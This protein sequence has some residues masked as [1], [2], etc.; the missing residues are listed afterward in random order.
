MPSATKQTQRVVFDTN[1]L[2]RFQVRLLIDDLAQTGVIDPFWSVQ[3]ETELRG[4]LKARGR[5]D[6]EDFIGRWPQARVDQ[7]RA[8]DPWLAAKLRDQSDRHVIEAA[9][10]V[11]AGVIVTDNPRDF[12]LKVLRRLGLDRHSPDAF[13]AAQ[14]Q[15]LRARY[16][17]DDLSKGRLPKTAKA[18]KTLAATRE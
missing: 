2:F 5:K 10:A 4:A 8:L 12:P 14:A 13:F 7:G 3:T 17:P 11:D 18:L 9:L 16:N 15:D 6:A 1:A